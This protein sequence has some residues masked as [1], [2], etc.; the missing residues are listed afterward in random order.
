MQAN[1]TVTANHMNNQSV[2]GSG[3][4]PSTLHAARQQRAYAHSFNTSTG[5]LPAPFLYTP[6]PPSESEDFDPTFW[7]LYFGLASYQ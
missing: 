5:T 6:S 2:L 3:K 1:Q 7:E 4:R